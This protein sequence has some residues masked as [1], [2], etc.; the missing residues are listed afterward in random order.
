MRYMVISL[1]TLLASG[2]ADQA[3]TGV[4]RFSNNQINI[5]DFI[6]LF[7]K[8]K[9]EYR[10]ENYNYLLTKKSKRSGEERYVVRND[11]IEFSVRVHERGF[12]QIA[13]YNNNGERS[14]E[15]AIHDF[16]FLLD[17]LTMKDVEFQVIKCPLSI[18]CK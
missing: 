2:C 12:S 13:V 15:K 14:E 1:L 3:P 9:T 16:K 8:S 6:E 10:I 7:V 17:Q 11:Q 18:I 4:V 5:N